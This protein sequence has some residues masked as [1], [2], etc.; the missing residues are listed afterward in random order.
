MFI[1]SF[2]KLDVWQLSRK[3]AVDLYILTRSF[4]KEEMYGLSG[5]LRR[6]S[7][8]VASNIA[9]GTSRLTAKDKSHF[10]TIA[11]SSLMETL[12]QLIIARDLDYINEDK[13]GEL[14]LRINEIGNKIN[15]LRKSQIS[16]AS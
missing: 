3:L 5:Q 8:S 16:Q 10:S 14:R 6:A 13:L 9:E 11:F 7:L 12:N 15:A 4:P 1:Y 2:E